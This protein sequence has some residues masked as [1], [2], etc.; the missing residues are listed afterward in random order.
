MAALIRITP[1][2]GKLKILAV[3]APD[4]ETEDLFLISLN[5]AIERLRELVAK[6]FQN[7]DAELA[8]ANLNLDTGAAISPGTSKTVDAAYAELLSRLVRGPVTP[9]EAVRRTSFSIT[10][11]PTTHQHKDTP[12]NGARYSAIWLR[13]GAQAP[14]V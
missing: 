14:D 11:I 6:L 7:Q 8:L 1:K 2:I 4:P 12:K 3:K 10:R 5:H 13:S 9:P